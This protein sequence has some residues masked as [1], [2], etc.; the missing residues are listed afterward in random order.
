MTRGGKVKREAFAYAATLLEQAGPPLEYH[1]D[2]RGRFSGFREDV[3]NEL[4]RE[5]RVM[6]KKQERPN[7][8][9]NLRR[10]P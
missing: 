1:R 10:E 7:G 8:I 3:W 5:L 4:I 9:A 2:S 6:S